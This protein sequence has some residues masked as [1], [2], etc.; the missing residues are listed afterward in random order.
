MIHDTA[1]A[2]VKPARVTADVWALAREM[3]RDG[4]ILDLSEEVASLADLE[5]QVRQDPSLS[6]SERVDLARKLVGGRVT[7]K[8]AY[9]S[10]QEKKRTVM[11]HDRFMNFL[12]EVGA[13]LFKRL[14]DD[15]AMLA[16]IGQDLKQL[17]VRLGEQ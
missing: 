14:G 6:L 2:T 4:G 9:L 7:A 13:I 3:A 1:Q 17:V 16:L 12:Q 11:T 15:P 8:Q 10:V 5:L